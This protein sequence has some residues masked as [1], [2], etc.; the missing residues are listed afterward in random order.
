MVPSFL[1]VG[2]PKCGTTALADYLGQ[3]P[4]V[5]VSEPKEPTFFEREYDRGLDFYRDTYF[6]GWAGE[7][8]TGEARVY[9]LYLDY[10]PERIRESLPEAKLIAI[11]RNPV[12][13]VFSQWWHRVTRAHEPRSFDELVEEELSRI[14][15]EGPLPLDADP[16]SWCRNL[17]PNTAGPQREPY[18]EV[19]YYARQLERYRALFPGE[20]IRV[21]FHDELARAPARLVHDLLRF[22]DV[23]PNGGEVDFGRR[24]AARRRQRGRLAGRLARASW[25]LGVNRIMPDAM[26]SGVARVLA[27]KT[28]ERPPMSQAAAE[29]LARHYRRHDDDLERL[30]GRALPWRQ[31]AAS[32]PAAATASGAPG[33][34][35]N[36]R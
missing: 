30:L 17:F 26:R 29:R 21:V 1:I 35:S 2:A 31:R 11:L 15:R 5:Y 25:R 7:P 28:V 19:G 24:N 22:L 20:Q 12:D 9:N 14:A 18:V 10:V 16:A 36:A 8:A 32:E 27:G 23:D 33:G 3:H 6:R 13:R 4:S 34:P